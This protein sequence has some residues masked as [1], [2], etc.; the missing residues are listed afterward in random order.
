VAVGMLCV[1]PLPAMLRHSLLFT[2][3]WL[4]VR[5]VLGGRNGGLAL[6]V[7]S[8]MLAWAFHCGWYYIVTH[9]LIAGYCPSW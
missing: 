4:M 1:L 2:V 9:C 8:L 3:W 7:G 5:V 6:A